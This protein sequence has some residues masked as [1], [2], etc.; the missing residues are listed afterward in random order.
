MTKATFVKLNINFLRLHP[1]FLIKGFHSGPPLQT[2]CCILLLGLA[3]VFVCRIFTHD[4]VVI[5]TLKSTYT[6][7]FLRINNFKVARW[8]SSTLK[9]TSLR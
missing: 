4:T 1:K 8:Q 6:L 2:F 7:F 5:Y 9:W 3:F